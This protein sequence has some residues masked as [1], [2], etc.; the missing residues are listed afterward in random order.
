MILIGGPDKGPI[1]RKIH[2]HNAEARGVAGTMIQG[3]PGTEIQLGVVEGLPVQRI[4]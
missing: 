1:L 3:D 2:L 4:I